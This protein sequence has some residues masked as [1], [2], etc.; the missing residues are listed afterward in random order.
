[1][2]PQINCFVLLAK[3][4]DPRGHYLETFCEIDLDA[5]AGNLEAIK[6][7]IGDRE[8]ILAV[9][10]NAYGHGVVPICREALS[11]GVKRFG[12][13]T[14]NEGVQLRDAGVDG[15][16]IILTPPAMEQIPSVIYHSLTPNVV[17]RLFAEALSAHAVKVGAEV[18]IHIEVD[19]GMGRSGIPWYDAVGEIVAIAMLPNIK[20]A[21]IFTHFPV[22]D[23][24]AESDVEFTRLQIRRFSH[25]LSTLT[26]FKLNI[27]LVHVSN[28]AGILAHPIVGNAVRPGLLAYGLYPSEKM[29]KTIDVKPILSLKT[30]VIQIRDF[31]PGTSI[32]Y[33]RTYITDRRTRVAVIR[34]GYGDGLR[35]ALSNRGE[36]LIRGKRRPIV[37]RVCMDTTMVEVDD[38]V[39][40]DDEVVIIGSQGNESI[41]A[42]EHAKWCTTINYE[43]ITGISERVKRVYIKGGE[44]VEVI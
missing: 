9:K 34:A 18:S 29:R 10:A 30:R 28:S 7:K 44:V 37:G 35:R 2:L 5:F 27:P 8:I 33:G 6:K 36:V 17:S 21:G 15:E 1:M 13:A 38:N 24:D 3:M 12:V 40:L 43:I 42:D 39:K 16:I 11:C 26:E 20:I 41:T 31:P 19:T 23:S 22:A 32:S 4:H 25:I 14:L